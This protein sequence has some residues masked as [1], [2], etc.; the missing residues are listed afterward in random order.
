MSDLSV[1]T[2]IHHFCLYKIL[3]E[4]EMT[5]GRNFMNFI[6]Y[7]IAVQE[8]IAMEIH[9]LFS[10]STFDVSECLDYRKVNKLISHR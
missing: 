10:I 9:F 7:F 3:I 6:L 2:Q 1:S 5:A 8:K 4:S